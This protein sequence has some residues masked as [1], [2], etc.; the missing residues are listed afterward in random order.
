MTPDAEV[1]QRLL[2]QRHSCRAFRPEQVD[3]ETI[4]SLFG[5]AQRTASWCNTQPWQVHLLSGEATSRFAES[6][7]RHG[8]ASAPCSDLPVPAGYFG[9]YRDRRRETGFA[10]YESLGIAREDRAGRDAQALLNFSFFGAPHAAVI[11]TDREQGVYGA[12][13]CGGYVATLLLA[14]Q[15]LGL[16]AVP[17]AAIALH[18]D[19]VRHYLELPDDRLVVKRS[20]LRCW[21]DGQQ[22]LPVEGKTPGRVGGFDG[23]PYD[24]LV[25][26][27]ASCRRSRPLRRGRALVQSRRLGSRRS[28]EPALGA[29]PSDR[30][31]GTA[32]GPLGRA[33]REGRRS[34]GRAA[35]VGATATGSKHRRAIRPGLVI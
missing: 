18:S 29:A 27:H 1:L 33:L 31:S 30:G 35:V 19:H 25:N 2:A 16:A 7:T 8:L 5:L 3:P 22:G 10:L 13:D 12:V 6:L 24:R 14:A 15:A 23:R 26:S 32:P 11:T 21:F 4:S 9:V 17:Q 20:C 28:E 34:H